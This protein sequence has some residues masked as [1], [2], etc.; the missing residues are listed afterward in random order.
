[1][2]ERV[3][4][5]AASVAYSLATAAS[6]ENGRPESRSHAAWYT[7]RRAAATATCMSA[8]RKATP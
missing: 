7:S 6:L 1:V 3:A 8:Q 5:I 2:A 4:S